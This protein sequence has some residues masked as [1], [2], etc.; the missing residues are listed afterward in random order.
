MRKIRRS[1]TILALLMLSSCERNHDFQ[2]D[3]KVLGEQ[4][5]PIPFAK[6]T[7]L[8]WYDA[9]WDKMDETDTTF[10]TSADG[11]FK[12]QFKDGYK[13]I[14]AGVAKGYSIGVE[15]L[16]DPDSSPILLKLKSDKNNLDLSTIDLREH[17]IGNY[18][19]E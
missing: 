4:G 18:S 19:N 7:I 11:M 13:V 15:E 17:I 9:G 2:V 5:E 14:I 12:A 1:I 8:C 16:Y 10:T 6:V 3:G